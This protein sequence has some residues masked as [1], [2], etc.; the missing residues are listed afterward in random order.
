MDEKRG[1]ILSI[2]VLKH[3]LHPTV[4]IV[5]AA[6]Q[7][8][9]QLILADGPIDV[10]ITA[11]IDAPRLPIDHTAGKHLLKGTIHRAAISAH[12]ISQFICA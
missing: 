3:G 11:S 12:L 7:L 4:P 1:L 9:L 6:L 8:D 2:E 10:I 5:D